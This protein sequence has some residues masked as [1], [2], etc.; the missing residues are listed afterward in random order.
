MILSNINLDALSHCLVNVRLLPE[1]R[2]LNILLCATLFLTCLGVYIWQQKFKTENRAYLNLHF[3]VLFASRN[4]WY[5]D[6]HPTPLCNINNYMEI[7][8]ILTWPICGSPC[9]LNCN[10]LF[11]YAYD[12]L[13]FSLFSALH[14]GLTFNNSLYLY[15]VSFIFKLFYILAVFGIKQVLCFLQCLGVYNTIIDVPHFELLYGGYIHWL[16]CFCIKSLI[17][18]CPMYNSCQFLIS[19]ES[20]SDRYFCLW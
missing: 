17:F 18:C 15:T 7:N 2:Q 12:S 4:V 8:K 9:Y 13:A 19:A 6:L 10:R 14:V 20:I 16:P 5:A 1:S 11:Q 3:A